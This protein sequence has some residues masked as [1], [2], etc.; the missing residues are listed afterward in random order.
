MVVSGGRVCVLCV[1]HGSERLV[2]SSDVVGEGYGDGEAK[3]FLKF[4]QR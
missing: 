4:L 3:F 1:G 2:G